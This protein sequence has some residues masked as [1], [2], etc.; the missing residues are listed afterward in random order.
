LRVCSVLVPSYRRRDWLEEWTGELEVLVEHREAGR[1]GPYPGVVSFLLGAFPHAVWTRKE[2][3]TVDSVVQDI[4]YGLRMLRRG[5]GF[6]L[7]AILTLAL[8]IGANGAI[9]SLV[10]GLLL[11]SPPEVQEPDRL[12][13]IARSYEE[14]PRWDNWSW[15]AFQ[16]IAEEAEFLSGVAGFSTGSF[17]VGW[18]EELEPA[19]GEYVSGRYFGL[20]GVQPE[21]GRLLGPMDE[22]APGA[23]PVV[24][25]SHGFWMR[26]FAGD[27]QLLGT[28]IQI[29]GTPYEIVGVAPEG[30]VGVDAM[31]TPPELWVPAFQ[32]T[33][34]DGSVPFERWG[35]SWFYVFG[36]L[37]PETSYQVAE[38]SMER[39][40]LLLRGASEVNEGIR[41]LMA[42]GLGLTPEER[43]EATGITLLLGG[44]AFL[45]LLL[46]C[47]N[48]GNLFLAR[49]TTRE[50]EMGVR[51]AL[52]AGRLR[53]VR[54][55][56]T[57][58][59][60][61]AVAAGLVTVPLLAWAGGFLDD[62][63]PFALRVSLAPD[64]RVYLFLGGVAL[65][66]G[67]LF[68]VVPAW[69]TARR[70]L[71]RT[72]RDAG[73]AGGRG[74]T[75]FRDALVVGQLA[76]SLGLVSGAALLGRSVL[77]ANQ[78]D[79]G[80]DPDN[81]LV[82]FINLRAT[83]RYEGEE[84]IRFQEQLLTELEAIPGV[85]HAALAGQA[86]VVG[87][88]ASTTVR[89]ADRPD[90]PAAQFEAEF[91]VVTPGYFELMGIPLLQGRAFFS[92]QEEP[93]RVAVVNEALA[94]LY[95]PEGDAVGKELL[96]GDELLRVVGVVGDVQMRS[97]RAPARPGVYY[98]YHQETESYLVAHLRVRGGMTGA[99]AGMKAAVAAVDPHLPVTRI[100]ELRAGLARSLS[101]TRTFGMVVSVFAAL[102]LILSLV[103]L[104]GL[105]SY[106]VAQRQREMGI[107]MALGAPGQSLVRLV[108]RRGVVLAG[109]GLALGMG[110]ALAV[111][112]ALE[113]VLFG[114]AGGN[115]P[116]L[117][118]SG[119]LLFVAGLLAAWI[120]ARRASR[121][122][123][124]VS[125][126]E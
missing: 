126:R 19:R 50:M 98:P 87:G 26:G 37:A 17:V 40:S 74:R 35:S 3:W 81:L 97:L 120:P 71:S 76:I 115:P 65:V 73:T 18:G 22:E 67:V 62:L 44:I 54:Q 45:V 70:D 39:I 8:G 15:P 124:A 68:G 24:V 83:G 111:G 102:A 79:A 41:A 116:A 103:G 60:A 95:W 47:A 86:P 34:S 121:V 30:F 53:L 58:S 75:R 80:F 64:L 31:G 1:G 78:A 33:S 49:A 57:E 23:H 7:V 6:S 46:T 16:L 110:A 91:N 104:Y 82:G 101:E 20:L 11:R 108:L 12:V 123:A 10:N 4:R 119:A 90:D 51:Q 92:A 72:L 125:L 106:G 88:H 38:A 114:V 109:M 25:L 84:I 48:V 61:L 5:P 112:R 118:A 13:Q 100:T 43:A 117:M 28:T 66:A 94:R 29:G 2:E 36:R 56:M 96:L 77:N 42:P 69:I 89:A 122:D 32:R 99:I 52:G 107:R 93:E 63:F 27:P 9:F 14:A 105:I 21:L 55:L 59:L 85:T 113:G